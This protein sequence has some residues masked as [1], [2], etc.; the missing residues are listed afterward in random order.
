MMQCISICVPSIFE[1][2]MNNGKEY[3]DEGYRKGVGS[4]YCNCIKSLI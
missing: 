2:G 1:E 3:K 4:K